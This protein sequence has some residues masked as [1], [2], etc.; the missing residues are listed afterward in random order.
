MMKL[1]GQLDGERLGQLCNMCNLGTRCLQ[2]QWILFIASFSK[3]EVPYKPAQRVSRKRLV[4]A[5]ALACPTGCLG[6]A[7]VWLKGSWG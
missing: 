3:P 7:F 6:R 2:P 4:P 5:P 1:R